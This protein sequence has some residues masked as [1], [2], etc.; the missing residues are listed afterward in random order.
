MR[1]SRI[2]SRG[3]FSFNT[4]LNPFALLPGLM[5][6]G[7]G[8]FV[9]ASGLVS[10]GGGGGGRGRPRSALP[11]IL[12]LVALGKRVAPWHSLYDL[13]NVRLLECEARCSAVMH[14]HV[15]HGDHL[16]CRL[17]LRKL[18]ATPSAGLMAIRLTNSFQYQLLIFQSTYHMMG[19]GCARLATTAGVDYQHPVGEYGVHWNFFFTLAAVKALTAA[20]PVPQQH[21][22]LAGAGSEALL[23]V[24]GC[25]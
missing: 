3:F 1:I 11:H 7:V 12:A 2:V 16:T 14:V 8:S 18:V 4:V 24:A 19:A 20:L 5:D 13:G 17:R 9:V 22:L 23:E 15:G 6:V 10:V 25:C 21:S